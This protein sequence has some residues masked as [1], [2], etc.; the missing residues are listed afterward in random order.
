MGKK[1]QARSE[2]KLAAGVLSAMRWRCGGA[3]GPWR[4]D[5]FMKFFRPWWVRAAGQNG[6]R[7]WRAGCL[8]RDGHD[9]GGRFLRACPGTESPEPTPHTTTP[10]RLVSVD[11]RATRCKDDRSRLGGNGRGFDG[12]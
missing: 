12:H 3:D 9:C 7:G 5:A 4:D 6:R 11:I 8:E 2:R 1:R 10:R